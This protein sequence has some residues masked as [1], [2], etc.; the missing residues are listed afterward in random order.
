MRND[1]FLRNAQWVA[2]PKPRPVVRWELAAVVAVAAC[3]MLAGLAL[4]VALP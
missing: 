1:H 3:L 2:T 4:W